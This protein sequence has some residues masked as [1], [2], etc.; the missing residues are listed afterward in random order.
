M[1]KVTVL[2]VE[3]DDVASRKVR[4]SLLAHGYELIE[5]RDRA[6]VYQSIQTKK[7][8]LVIVSFRQN[9]AAEEF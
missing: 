1:K 2:I 7:P 3:R 5:S 6:G 9:E 4:S 8:D